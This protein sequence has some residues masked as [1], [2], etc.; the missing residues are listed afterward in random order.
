MLNAP[1]KALDARTEVCGYRRVVSYLADPS[2]YRPKV[3]QCALRPTTE[4]RSQATDR[5]KFVLLSGIRPTFGA[6]TASLWY[7]QLL[8]DLQEFMLHECRRRIAQRVLVSAAA[9]H[10]SDH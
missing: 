10:H 9:S 3:Q 5:G 4:R 2:R 6:A 8:R 1:V 7:F